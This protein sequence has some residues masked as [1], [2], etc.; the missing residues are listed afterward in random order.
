MNRILLL[1]ATRVLALAV[2]PFAHAE[3]WQPLGPDGGEVT[4][5]VASPGANGRV[6]ALTAGGLFKSDDAGRHWQETGGGLSFD[7]TY[8]S[9]ISRSVVTPQEHYLFEAGVRLM[10][11][12]DNGDSWT[13]TGLYLP[14][15][16]IA[17]AML[18]IPGGVIY[19]SYLGTFRSTDAGT[20]FA[21]VQGLPVGQWIAVL[22]MNPDSQHMLAG[23][24]I[25]T[26]GEP[27]VYRS[28]DL[29]VTW[30]PLLTPAQGDP[31]TDIVMVDAL[32]MA[33][34]LGDRLF[35]STDQ[36]ATWSQ[37]VTLESARLAQTTVGGAEL[38]VFNG[39][40]CLRSS[41]FFATTYPCDG[42]LPPSTYGDGRLAEVVAVSDG[43]SYRVLAT[44]RAIGVIALQGTASAWAPSNAQ[45]QAE[46]RRGLALAAED[47]SRFWSGRSRSDSVAP[48]VVRSDDGAQSWQGSL[49]QRA[50]S[51]RTLALD[52]TTLAAPGGRTL[53]AAGSSVRSQLA[54]I[55]S[56]IFK[57]IDDGRTWTS[58]DEG[59]P[60]YTGT[61]PLTGVMLSNVRKVLL[62]PRSCASP[63][64]QGACTSGPLGT[65]YALSNGSNSDQRFR[66]IKSTQAGANWIPVGTS[67]PDDIS[68]DA[69]YQSVDPVDI[70]IDSNGILYL[71]VFSNLEDEKGGIPT[72]TITSGV[73]R[74]NDGGQTWAPRNAGLPHVGDSATTTR[75]VF[76]LV[77]HP[78]QPGVVWASTI[79]AGQSSQIHLSVD[80][81]ENWK[82]IGTELKDCDVRD[83]Q[84]DS[85][86]PQV[87]YAAGIALN[88]SK[89]CI[90]RSE[91]GGFNWTSLSAGL[92]VHG[93]YDLRQQPQDH[94]RLVLATTSGLW[95][96]LVPSDRIFNDTE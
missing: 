37:R 67:L 75:D 15:G 44:A 40:Q 49:A 51:I 41:D 70:E 6:L 53:Y 30:V 79:E 74:S 5:L 28:T 29:G 55:T 76:A 33:V 57:S 60:P 2:A 84:I 16:A 69:S 52:P 78:R 23:T 90:W 31:V 95:H 39:R 17:S 8:G 54:P 18:A 66:V 10:R 11:S 14:S 12:E 35:V 65:V 89:G 86:A 71:S 38:I 36:G 77:I 22:R 1:S 25:R 63:P 47:P 64:V 21:P 24:A 19:S 50:Q 82:G 43:G 83:L 48:G 61:L 3:P 59:I 20:T 9:K 13:P 80:G 87:L 27:A 32:T 7:V 93:V 45:L 68:V 46:P 26:P 56:G 88:G 62:D 91:D 73:F 85:A 81:G 72:P 4:A 58:L 34:S 92:P 94:R 42:D 96:G